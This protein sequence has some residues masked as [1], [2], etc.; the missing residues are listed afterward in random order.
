[1]TPDDELLARLGSYKRNERHNTLAETMHWFRQYKLLSEDYA[2]RIRELKAQVEAEPWACLDCGSSEGFETV[3]YP[4]E[5]DYDVRCNECGSLH[6]DEARNALRSP[7]RDVDNFRARAEALQA[8]L[9]S[10]ERETIERC[11]KVCDEYPTVIVPF[12]I[13]EVARQIRA[14]APTESAATQVTIEPHPPCTGGNSPAS[15]AASCHTDHP[16]RHWDRTCPAC[17]PAAAPQVCPN[18][19]GEMLE[20]D[21]LLFCDACK[22]TIES[23]AKGKDHE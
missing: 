1:M 12:M 13:A 23:A 17:N 7:A 18:G 10:V 5:G 21:G 14:L 6:T 4:M 2:A 20:T 9:A 16:L 15:A 11:A 19:H 8:R 22:Y 3:R